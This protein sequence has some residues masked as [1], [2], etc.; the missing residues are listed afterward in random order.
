M[1]RSLLAER[2]RI[3]LR[4]ATFTRIDRTPFG[5]RTRSTCRRRLTQ[6]RRLAVSESGGPS[7]VRLTVSRRTSAAQNGGLTHSSLENS[8][9][10]SP[11]NG[12]SGLVDSE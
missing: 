11:E 6:R 12:E 1:R 9:V 7:R 10:M 5:V 4:P 3:A 8:R 2:T